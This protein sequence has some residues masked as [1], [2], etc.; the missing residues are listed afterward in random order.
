[1]LP[2]ANVEHA[3]TIHEQRNAVNIVLGLFY[4]YFQAGR[5]RGL[6]D[7]DQWV[8]GTS[9]WQERVFWSHSQPHL[10][11]PARPE[12]SNASKRIE[13]ARLCMMKA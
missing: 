6:R 7:A 2:N 12:A 10:V 3:Q 9:A 1:L 8:S 11:Q 5:R 4:K 13:I